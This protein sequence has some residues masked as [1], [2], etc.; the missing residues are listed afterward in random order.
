MVLNLFA[1]RAESRFE[2]FFPGFDGA[3]VAAFFFPVALRVAF[4]AVAAFFAEGFFAAFGAAFLCVAGFFATDFFV[5]FFAA[6]A[7]TFLVGFPLA[8]VEAFFP[9]T[10]FRAV[11]FAVVFL[12]VADFPAARSVFGAVFFFTAIVLPQCL[13]KGARTYHLTQGVSIPGKR[14]LGKRAHLRFGAV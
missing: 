13:R 8:F 11:V 2:R 4:P 10:A 3:A 5:D 6:L 9:A 1:F 7:A 12:R 14:S